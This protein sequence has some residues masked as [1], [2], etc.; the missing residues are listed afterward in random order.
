MKTRPFGSLNQEVPII[1]QGTWNMPTRKEKDWPDAIAALKAG[2]K[3]GMTHIDTAEMYGSGESEELIKE[4]ISDFR[5]DDLFIISKVLP[6]NASYKGTIRS[7]EASLS[8]M[9]LD[10]LDCYLLHWRGNYPLEETMAGMEQLIKEGKIRSLGVS[11]FDVD[12]LKEAAAHLS[13][14]K[15]V[16]NQ[17]L[18][19]LNERGIDRRLI[20]YCQEK[21]IAVVGYTPF[22]RRKIEQLPTAQQ[23]VLQRLG[24]K[25][26]ATPRQI[27]LAFLVRLPGLFTIP[28]ASKHQHT[29]ENAKAGDIELEKDDLSV[30]NEAFPVPA[31]DAPLALL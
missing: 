19:H 17:V 26:G 20:P 11:N 29:M 1:G 22:G 24:K 9:K 15:I 23:E 10:H 27:I 18:Y 6:T 4:A 30:L 2:I 21:S 25:Y 8:R 13:K 5:R 28:K 3:A 12:D 16:C 7:C 31:K 14:E